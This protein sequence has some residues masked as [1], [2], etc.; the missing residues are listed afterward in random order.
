MSASLPKLVKQ[1]IVTTLKAVPQDIRIKCVRALA[2]G[3]PAVVDSIRYAEFAGN[4]MTHPRLS[5]AAVELAYSTGKAKS[6]D[7]KF[8]LLSDIPALQI[9]GVTKVADPTAAEL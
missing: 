2:L 1:A 3:S 7:A 6:P 8:F 4:Y 5:S 9:P